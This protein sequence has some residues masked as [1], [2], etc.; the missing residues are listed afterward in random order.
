MCPR[1]KFQLEELRER[2]SAVI[3][4]A[5]LKVFAERG[6]NGSTISMIA[7]EAGI[8]KGLLYTYFESKEILLDNLL[9]FGLKKA[10]DFMKN[11]AVPKPTDKKSFASGLRF[12]IKLFQEENDFWRLY[13]MLI[14][15]K[16][17]TQKF[18]KELAPFFRLYLS[19]Y[20]TYFKKKGSS[21]PKAEAIL[22]GAVLDGIMFDIMVAPHQYP[23]D[24]VIN[25][26]IKKFA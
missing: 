12:M 7:E 20:E 15:Q 21:N 18:E 8:S 26:I 19:V 14:L 2:K 3:L 22:F 1:S 23:L 13:C 16:N 11:G 4:E 10:A 24:D 17:M 9:K 6:Y 5:A 25:M